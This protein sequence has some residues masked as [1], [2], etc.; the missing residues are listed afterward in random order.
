LV[1][2]LCL[3]LSLLLAGCSTASGPTFNE[4]ATLPTGSTGVYVY[5]VSHLVAGFGATIF[6]D[7]KKIGYLKDNGFIFT[8]L[9]P[10]VHI[11]SVPDRSNILKTGLIDYK[12]KLAAHQTK[13]IRLNWQ[14]SG[15]M[16][17][18]SAGP[19]PEWNWAFEEIPAGQA[20]KQ[21]SVT[22]LSND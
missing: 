22:H 14:A 1:K 9:T 13:F 12:F 10:G 3:S 2:Y 6:V 11:I 8:S 20:K 21:L 5:R 19:V 15:K 7:G 18:L 4:G 16:Q 17:W